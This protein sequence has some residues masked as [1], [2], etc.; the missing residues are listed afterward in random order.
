MNTDE[1]NFGL[2]VIVILLFYF[3]PTM[4]GYKKKNA[5]AIFVLNLFLGWTLI[6]WV[7]ALVWATTKD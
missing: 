3:I 4:V 1:L 7:V 6:G 5:G 2:L